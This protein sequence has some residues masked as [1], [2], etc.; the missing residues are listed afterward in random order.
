MYM[1]IA[2]C[3]IILILTA[4]IYISCILYIVFDCAIG[5]VASFY[6]A[7][8]GK[9]VEELKL[10]EIVTR[11]QYNTILSILLKDPAW[12]DTPCDAICCC[13]FII[14]HLLRLGQVSDTMISQIRNVYECI[15]RGGRDI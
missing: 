9:Q 15:D 2:C 13:D 11:D 8:A 3:V 14:L 12:T 10:R 1:Y 6:I 7:Y 4:Y 5:Q